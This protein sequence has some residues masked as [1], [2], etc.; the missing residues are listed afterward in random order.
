MIE[1]MTILPNIE[2]LKMSS[3]KHFYCYIYFQLKEIKQ[4]KL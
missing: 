2:K 3:E 1:K 4:K